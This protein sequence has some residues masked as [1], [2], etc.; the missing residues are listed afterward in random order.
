MNGVI[1]MNHQKTDEGSLPKNLVS[2]RTMQRLTQERVAE[3]IGVTRQAVAKWEAGE[4]V[5]DIVRCNALAELYGV[6][7]D[8]LV[9]YD[10]VKEGIGMPPKGKHLFGTVQMGARGQIVIPKNARETLAFKPGDTLMVLG[11][12]NPG[13]AGLALVSAD[14]FL[15]MAEQALQK[16]QEEPD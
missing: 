9:N 6:T 7:L 12:T 8:D 2:L 1:F 10:A 5:P 4:S 3:A 16:S 11:D 14:G 15:K 13:S